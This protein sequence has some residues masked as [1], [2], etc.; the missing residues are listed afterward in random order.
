MTREIEDSDG[1][2]LPENIQAALREIVYWIDDL[3]DDEDDVEPEPRCGAQAAY[4]TC[5]RRPHRDAEHAMQIGGGSD[6]FDDPEVWFCWGPG[7]RVTGYQVTALI[8]SDHA[9]GL[10]NDRRQDL[11]EYADAIGTSYAKHIPAEER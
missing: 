11:D 10:R 3:T 1:A 2:P 9:H 6:P 5:S 8:S 7:D 4:G